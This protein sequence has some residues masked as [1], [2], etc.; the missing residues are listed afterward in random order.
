MHPTQHSTVYLRAFLRLVSILLTLGLTMPAFAEDFAQIVNQLN[1]KSFKE[2]AVIVDKLAAS[3]DPRTTQTLQAMLDNRLYYEKATG[4]IL[5][6]EKLDKDFAAIELLS[7]LDRGTLSKKQIKK[8]ATNNKLRKQLRTAISTLSISH[9]DETV[10]LA[11][12]EQM[13]PGA[14]ADMAALF[15]ARI[16]AEKS[17]NV[18]ELMQVVIDLGELESSDMQAQLAA[19]DRL[20]SR[21]EPG[22]RNRLGELTADSNPAVAAAASKALNKIESRVRLYENLKTVFFG[23]DSGCGGPVRWSLHL[24]LFCLLDA[25]PRCV[26]RPRIRRI[27]RQRFK[28]D[29]SPAWLPILQLRQLHG[30]L[31]EP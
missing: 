27:P 13:L 19:I 7:E 20:G 23:G 3:G 29:L 22:V 26:S 6:V 1:T 24:H 11:S 18:R 15:R 5:L 9:P 4:T 8:V 31:Q 12:V 14:D 10:R 17:P 16:E 30:G 25:C 2:K 28:Q 21:L